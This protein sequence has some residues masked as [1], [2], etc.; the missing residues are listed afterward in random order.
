M[1]ENLRHRVMDRFENIEQQLNKL[2]SEIEE[3]VEAKELPADLLE[4]FAQLMIA[5][6]EIEKVV[7]GGE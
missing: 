7:Y 3:V 1:P 2:N 4:Q 6:K 5:F